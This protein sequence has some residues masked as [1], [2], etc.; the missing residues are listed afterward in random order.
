MFEDERSEDVPGDGEGDDVVERVV[1]DG[2]VVLSPGVVVSQV[3]QQGGVLCPRVGRTE[4]LQEMLVPHTSHCEDQADLA[5]GPD[6][7]P[8]HQGPPL[9]SHQSELSDWLTDLILV[10]GNNHNFHILLNLLSPHAD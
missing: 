7:H 6:L 4:G 9:S 8:E 1:V 10:A 5:L 3:H 2:E